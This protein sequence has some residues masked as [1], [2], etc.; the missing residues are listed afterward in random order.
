[1]LNKPNRNNL[2][3]QVT[4]YLGEMILSGECKPGESLPQEEML[5]E[6]LS[7]SR[8]VIREAI[9][10][11]AAKGLVNS[12]PRLGTEV[13]PM[14][15][16]NY[17]DPQVL[18]WHGKGDHTLQMLHHLTEL[19]QAI[20]PAAA[21]MAAIR[22][23]DE[24]LAAIQS[25]YQEMKDH[26][27]NMDIYLSSDLAFHIAILKATGNPFFS[28]IAN[29][30]ETALQT[31]LEMTN[32]DAKANALSVPLHEEICK[33]IVARDPKRARSAMIK[34]MEDTAGRLEKVQDLKK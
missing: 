31:S 16:W 22:A 33:A 15:C 21:E 7:V 6:Q 19:R 29:V 23:S 5:C 11:L 25:A 13:L 27:N 26:I 14:D 12:R 9:K 32:Q 24:E 10:S 8:T 17:L 4:N 28:P 18:E 30:V 34:H 1:M 3:T 2:S 20:E